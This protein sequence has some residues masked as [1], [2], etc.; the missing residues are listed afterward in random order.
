MELPTGN[1]NHELTT[2][3]KL[4]TFIEQI[5]IDK[6]NEKVYGQFWRLR[7]FKT[8]RNIIG[9]EYCITMDMLS[10]A[11]MKAKRNPGSIGARKA[12]G[13]AK[14]LRRKLKRLKIILSEDFK[15]YY[16]LKPQYITARTDIIIPCGK[17]TE[18]RAWKIKDY[19][20]YQGRT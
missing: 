3:K 13:K 11:E 4:L 2:Q 19:A 18:R 20:V 14:E 9:G 12:K 16:V 8:R 5:E 15:K 6:E 1:K 10:K 17:I 7:D